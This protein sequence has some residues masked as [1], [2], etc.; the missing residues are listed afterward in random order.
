MSKIKQIIRGCGYVSGYGSHPGTLPVILFIL[1][2]GLAGIERGG[3]FGF[4]GGCIFMSLFLVP[5]YLFGAY[6][7]GKLSDKK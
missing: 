4:L 7:R 3:L 6:E 5:I 2:G 1:L